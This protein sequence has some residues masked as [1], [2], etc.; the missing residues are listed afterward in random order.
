[1]LQEHVKVCQNQIKE[2]Q[3]ANEELEQYGRRLCVRTDGVSTVDNKT[4]DDVLD[5]VKS[6]IKETSCDIPDVVIDR[7][8]RIRKGY[9]GKKKQMFLVKVSFYILQLFLQVLLYVL[10]T[11]QCFIIVELI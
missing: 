11:E 3:Q 4:S 2:M 1:M 7:T 9:N 10:G 6:L 8:R 5:K